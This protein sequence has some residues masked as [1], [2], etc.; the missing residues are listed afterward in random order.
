MLAC[1]GLFHPLRGM[2]LRCL[3]SLS[4]L[5]TSPKQ[6]K[7]ENV[8]TGACNLFSTSVL[9]PFKR[10][11]VSLNSCSSFTP[12]DSI[13]SN[14]SFF[15]WTDSRPDWVAAWQIVFCVNVTRLTSKQFYRYS[16]KTAFPF[17]CV[18]LQKHV[19]FPRETGLKDSLW[20]GRKVLHV[21]S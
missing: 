5:H 1:Q 18:P 2:G 21:S 19:S 3:R 16:N 10:G 8:G 20:S 9:F 6:N 14:L 12:A 17:I 13:W 4:W 15:N 7:P 11:I